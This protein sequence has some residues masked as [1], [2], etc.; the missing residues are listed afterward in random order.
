VSL[1]FSAEKESHW[2]TRQGVACHTVPRK[3]GVGNRS[4]NLRWDRHLGLLPS[5]TNILSI[6][7]KRVLEAWKLT[8]AVLSA[9][10]LPKNNGEELDA[11]AKRVVE[12]MEAEG[13]K[14][15]EFGANVHRYAER[16]NMGISE[17]DPKLEPYVES[18]KEWFKQN[19]K[20]VLFAERIL[21]NRK[22]GYAGTA[23][24]GVELNDSRIV[25]ADFKTQKVKDKPEFYREW[26]LQLVAYGHCEDITPPDAYM[27]I[28]IDSTKPAP[29][30]VH[31]WKEDYNDAWI[32]FRA[33]AYG[34]CWEHRYWPGK[35]GL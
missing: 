5:V 26:L 25:F 33:F 22:I 35:V 9:L 1:L 14:A 21:V 3:S 18:Y 34:W 4:V 28:V 30:A 20:R 19:V 12:D 13:K 7:S 10:T 15:S 2:Y 11:F 24:L 23:D 8:Q 29:V 16:F 6:K 31:E 17:V 32:A 27:S